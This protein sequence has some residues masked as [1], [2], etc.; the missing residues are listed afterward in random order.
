MEDMKI[1]GMVD[2]MSDTDGIPGYSHHVEDNEWGSL[3]M[4]K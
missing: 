4:G 3:S 1:G 2:S